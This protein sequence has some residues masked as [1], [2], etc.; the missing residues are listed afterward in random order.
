[1]S[2]TSFTTDQIVRLREIERARLKRGASGLYE[3]LKNLI[4]RLESGAADVVVSTDER[5]RQAK[6]LWDKGFGRELLFESF[7]DY[8][9]SI[10]QIPEALKTKDE[11]FSELMLVDARADLERVCDL[12][13]VDYDGDELT[14]QDIKNP[15]SGE[16]CSDDGDF[17]FEVFENLKKPK[18]KGVYWIRAQDGRKNNGKSVRVCRKHFAEGEVGLTDHEGLAFFVQ[19]PESL[20]GRGMDLPGSVDCVGVAACLCWFDELPRLDSKCDGEEDEHP[21]FGAA[22]RREQSS[23]LGHLFLFDS[24]PFVTPPFANGGVSIS[25]PARRDEEWQME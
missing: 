20:K 8:L 1:M 2:D 15:R 3:P 5:V 18:N 16:V 22:S 9:L 21:N 25:R 17:S 19:N 4:A 10:P 23:I 11:H 14:F 7:D 12:L 6:V 24:Q 13:C